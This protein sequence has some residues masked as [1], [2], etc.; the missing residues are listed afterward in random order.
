[1]RGIL[2]LVGLCISITNSANAQQVPSI[3][4]M[5]PSGGQAGTSVDVVLG[6]YD[7]TPD[8]QVFVHDPRIKLEITGKPGPVIVPEPPYWFGKKA[9]RSP[10]L[11][12]RETQA[13][14]TIPADVPP[15]VVRW[16]VANANGASA[17]GFF[18]VSAD[19][20]VIEMAEQ[21][22]PQ[23]L[24]LLPVIVSGQ[25]KK[26]EEVDSYRFT[27]EKSGPVSCSLCARELG[28][29]LNAVIEV[30][31]G[32]GH[33]IASAADT[34]G[35]DTALTFVGKAGSEYTLRIYDLDF[36]GNRAF[37][38]RLRVAAEPR[39]IAALPA[40]GKRGET[41]EVELIGYG[42]ATG[43]D[44]LEVV[45]TEIAFPS[46]KNTDSFLYRLKTP[47][48]TAAPIK[49]HLSNLPE[50]VSSSG[51]SQPI[52]TLP[53]AINGVLEKRFGEHR[54]RI[55]AKK[56]E[57]LDLELSAKAIGSPLDV[58]LAVYDAQG[59]EKTRNDDLPGSTDAA[60]QFRVP[61]DGEYEIGVSDVSG[62]S[63]NRAAVY[64]LLIQHTQPGISFTVPEL[65]NIPLG[66]K[67]KITLKATRSGG[68]QE[69]VPIT[70]LG[71]PEGVTVPKDLSIPA[72]KTA[73][74]IDFTVS[75]EAAA[76]AALVRIVGEAKTEDQSIRFEAG[77][78][79]LA[80]T[81]TPPFSIDAEGKDDVTKWPRGT[82][83]PAPV[84]IERNEG[85]HN[86]I[87]LEMASKQGRHRQG[88]HGPE[89]SVPDGVTRILYPVTLPEW[90]ET[91]RT[92]RMI[93][94]GLAQVKDPKGNLRYSLSRQKTRM[95]FLPT[96]ALLK[97]AA[98]SEEFI[99]RPGQAITVPISLSRSR[100]LTKPALLELR[101]TER[102][103]E[104]FTAESQ[105][106]APTQAQ[107]K[108]QI[109]PR[110][111]MPNREEETLTI[112]AT[113]L[114]RD[115]TPVVSET[116]VLIQFPSIKS[117]ARN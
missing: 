109:V 62:K 105:T 2:I 4:Y 9:R 14:L 46:E 24:E 7:W 53:A 39:V 116:Q 56:G 101:L 117:T 17:V 35:R 15:G 55:S 23:V 66:G 1:M 61:V 107:T 58:S 75:P 113:V 8:M 40:V 11:L 78:L 28:S 94:N 93:V 20:E 68:F 49:L 100:Q 70:I 51:N 29:E 77:P 90:L 42:I 69:A 26:I 3:G 64:R 102:Q 31:E 72:K 108:F 33:L 60:L 30:Y 41:R 82:I 95:G 19:R 32:K 57:T 13:K 5:Y 111:N 47:F 74:N 106:I 85:F 84:L 45:K 91:T 83:F 16:Q 89:L 21:E 36:R 110:E 50:T 97:L 92:S 25:I 27:L 65:L 59:V 99:T 67:G 98:D 79:L 96:G 88:I 37:V 12:P 103:Q 114:N 54:Y 104:L 22:T 80:T 76:S 71:L 86:E 44:K 34:A 43:S 52:T 63:G 10:F 81:I 87:V 112:R 48:G 18:D 38:Y 115:N 6:G 73:L